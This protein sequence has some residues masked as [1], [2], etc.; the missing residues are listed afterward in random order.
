MIFSMI[1]LNVCNLLPCNVPEL[2][3]RYHGCIMSL[4]DLNLGPWHQ[5]YDFL[6]FWTDECT[7]K[8]ALHAQA[9]KTS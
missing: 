1:L 2:F 6:H 4:K 9:C 7:L 3:S 8:R 5:K